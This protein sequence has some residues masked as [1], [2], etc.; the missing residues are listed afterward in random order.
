MEKSE[1]SCL[2]VCVAFDGHTQHDKRANELKGENTR[3]GDRAAF[4]FYAARF[5]WPRSQTEPQ[6][7]YNAEM[8]SSTPLARGEIRRSKPHESRRESEA[9]ASSVDG[10]SPCSDAKRNAS[11]MR[12][13]CAKN[14]PPVLGPPLPCG[15]RRR[16]SRTAG[17]EASGV[18]L[19]KKN[20]A[21]P[22]VGP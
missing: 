18:I 22:L 9:V 11:A 21:R 7:M 15:M 17:E 12:I 2:T 10:K 3:S 4:R 13:P 16:L 5:R 8:T 20:S 6:S 14:P 19:R 1:K